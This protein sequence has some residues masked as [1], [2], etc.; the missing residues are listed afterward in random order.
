MKRVKIKI[1][2]RKIEEERVEFMMFVIGN[3]SSL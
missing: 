3:L 1:M 2:L